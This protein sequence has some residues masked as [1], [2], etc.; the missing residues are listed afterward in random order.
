MCWIAYL[1]GIHTY[2][3]PNV[4]PWYWYAVLPIIWYP[5]SMYFRDKVDRLKGGII[6]I[7]IFTAYYMILNYI[8][9][10]GLTNAVSIVFVGL[11]G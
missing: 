9:F 4:I 3:T 6:S 10:P 5:V 7:C 1:V 2:K 11:W 8:L